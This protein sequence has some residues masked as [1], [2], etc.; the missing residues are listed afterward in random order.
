MMSGIQGSISFRP[1]LQ[2]AYRNLGLTRQ[3]K[4]A[5]NVRA[6]RAMGAWMTREMQ[7][8]TTPAGQGQ[9]GG[10]AWM[11]L[12]EGW[13]NYKREV[14]APLHMGVFSQGRSIAGRVASYG[15]RNSISF[16]V[17]RTRLEVEAGPT[18]RHAAG[19][20]ALRILTPEE[21]YA[22]KRFEDIVIDTWERPV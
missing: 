22:A 13:L 17:R 10:Q 9:P 18:V 20:D 3:Q 21:K 11:P 6:L 7:K 1:S 19:F 8:A 14:G 2:E 5:Q 4:T 16:D 12:S 15:M